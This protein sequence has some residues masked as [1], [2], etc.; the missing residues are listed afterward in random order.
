[1]PVP[2]FLAL[3]SLLLFAFP[4]QTWS[5]PPN[6]VLLIS[7]DQAWGDYG[8]MGHEAIQTPNL[9]K[10]AEE[11]LTFTRGYVPDSLCR[12]SLVTIVTGRYPHQ[13]GIVGNDPPPPSD[14][15]GKPKRTI[16]SDPRYLPI[17]NQYIEHIDDETTLADYL[18]ENLGYTSH[19]SGKWWEGHFSRGGFTQGMTHG[20]RTKGGRHGDLGLKIGRDG[21]EPVLNYIDESVENDSPFFVYYAP[22]LPHTPH[23]PPKRLLD[24][25]KDKTPHLP[26]AKYWAMCEWFDETCGEL[27]NHLEEKNVADNTIVLYVTDNGWINQ[28][29]RSAYAPRSKR[30]Q[31]EGGVRTPIMVR[32]NGKVTP[33]MDTT[34]LASSIDL[35]PTVLAAVGI[36]VP[37]SFDGIN[38]LDEK[39][40]EAR[41]VIFGEIFEHDIRDMTDPVASLRYRWI[42]EGD[43]KLIVPHKPVEE[44][45]KT[46]LF[47]LADDPHEEHNLAKDNPELVKRL[48]RRINRWWK[49]NSRA[50]ATQ[51]S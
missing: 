26:V 15:V 23:N 18:H 35:V 50:A 28:T 37:E 12:P 14:L 32:W 25:Y 2:R 30:S 49:V 6:V 27:L 16:T 7:D 38:L 42:I 3:L 36:D 17:R 9:D 43:W 1:M 47:N 8:F 48:R 13:H 4:V 34:H 20:D 39:A 22:F 19:Q 51:G 29:E 11:S 21:M 24:K 46:E 41:D 5:A 45:G 33:K 44:D 10:L 31:Y 40:V